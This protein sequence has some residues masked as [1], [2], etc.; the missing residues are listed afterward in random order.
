[1]RP[2]N[3]AALIAGFLLI[4]CDS[5]PAGAPSERFTIAVIPDTQNYVDYTHQISK[6]FAIDGSE[7]FLAQMRDVA[8]RAVGNGGDVVF[9][10]Q[11][12]V[13]AQ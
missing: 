12:G 7:L 6:G 1:M 5:G 13:I 3:F 11:R 2:T 4:G 10:R 9:D 8:R